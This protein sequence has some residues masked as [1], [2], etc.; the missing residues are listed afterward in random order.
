MIFLFGAM[1]GFV[2]GAITAGLLAIWIYQALP[3]RPEVFASTRSETK[4]QSQGLSRPAASAPPVASEGK[5]EAQRGASGAEGAAAGSS[6]K[7]ASGQTD[8]AATAKAGAPEPAGRRAAPREEVEPAPTAE[9]RGRFW[10]QAGAY[11]QRG[12][13][14]AQRARIAILGY[15]AQ[16]YVSESPEKG[17]LHRV[18]LG[19]FRDPEEAARIRSELAREG[20]EVSV[21]RASSN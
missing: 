20:I 15:E 16:V 12:E 17:T 11:A 21:V 8:S 2:F 13:A 3:Y 19:P 6:G 18:R 10:L 14:D 1:I 4:A 9:V 5:G 7:A